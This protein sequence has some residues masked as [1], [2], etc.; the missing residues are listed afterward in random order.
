LTFFDMAAMEGSLIP[1][2]KNNEG[3]YHIDG[4]LVLAPKELQW[5]FFQQLAE[6]LADFK[7]SR[8]VFAAPL[9]RYLEGAFCEDADHVGN[10]TQEDFKK[11]LEEE[12]Y[13]ARTNIKNSAFRCGFKNAVM[14][15]TW[16]AVKKTEDLWDDPVHLKQAG[17]MKLADSI[18]L[19]LEELR[20]KRRSK[21]EV[22][23]GPAMKKQRLDSAS[24]PTS[25]G[26]GRGAHRGRGGVQHKS[27]QPQR[28]GAHPPHGLRAR[29]RG[30][31]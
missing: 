14:I 24:T 13:L 11:K 10:R 12:V 26:R 6:E 1:P 16:G 3:N 22:E 7:S 19:A 21:L 4:D 9:P 25:P 20:G 17:Y 5:K 29:G 2:R 31:Y 8:I 23:V 27:Q 15:S 28:G 18:L 30:S